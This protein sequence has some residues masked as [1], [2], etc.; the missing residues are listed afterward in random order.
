MLS[1]YAGGLFAGMTPRLPS[2]TGGG[3]GWGL[4]LPAFRL[5]LDGWIP[6]QGW[7][8]ET[9]TPPTPRH[10]RGNENPSLLYAS[11]DSSLDAG[12]P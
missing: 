8:D 3:L 7:N 1:A 6:A 11:I 12:R 5:A 9:L 4:S 2:P 10:S